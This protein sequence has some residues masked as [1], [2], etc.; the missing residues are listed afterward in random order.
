MEKSPVILRE[1]KDLKI[2]P[3]AFGRNRLIFLTGDLDDTNLGGFADGFCP[4]GGA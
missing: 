4:V 3:L 2:L 1:M